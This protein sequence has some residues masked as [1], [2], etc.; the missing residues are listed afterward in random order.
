MSAIKNTPD[1]WGTDSLA[2]FIDSAKD[3]I[4]ASY[5]NQ[6][7]WYKRLLEIHKFYDD[8]KD[9]LINTPNWFS[10]FLGAVRL[11]LSGQVPE[12]QVIL[13]NSIEY[14]LYGLYVCKKPK[15][16][17]IWLRRNDDNKSKQFMRQEF[18]YSNLIRCLKSEDIETYETSNE[19]AT[20]YRGQFGLPYIVLKIF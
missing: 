10:A 19:N 3:N 15:S 13:R 6:N 5:V 12:T 11:I 17:E 18:L 4:F 1:N 7:M 2:K 16:Q 8:L 20:V 14:A 9:N